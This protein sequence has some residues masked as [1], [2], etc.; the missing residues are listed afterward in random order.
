MHREV[1]V[2]MHCSRQLLLDHGADV[3]AWGGHYGNALQAASFGGDDAI[4]R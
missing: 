3:S 4:V 2:G 1:Q